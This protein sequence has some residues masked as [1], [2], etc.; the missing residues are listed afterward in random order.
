MDDWSVLGAKPA[1]GE[2]LRLMLR[3]AK[4]LEVGL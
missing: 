2:G 3:R 4:T 1:A